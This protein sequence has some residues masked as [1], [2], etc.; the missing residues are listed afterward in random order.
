M[1]RCIIASIAGYETWPDGGDERRGELGPQHPSALEIRGQPKHLPGQ[2]YGRA[3]TVPWVREVLDRNPT[4]WVISWEDRRMGSE[5]SDG[6]PYEIRGG[7]EQPARLPSSLG[8][9]VGTGEPHGR[10]DDLGQKCKK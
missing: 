4:R 2:G 9:L 6:P 1:D 3:D 5:G 10:R 8:K 7:L